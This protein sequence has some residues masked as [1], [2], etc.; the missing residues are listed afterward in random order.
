MFYSGVIVLTVDGIQYGI[1]NVIG[2]L[3]V[4]K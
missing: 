1:L 2:P 4:T 3:K